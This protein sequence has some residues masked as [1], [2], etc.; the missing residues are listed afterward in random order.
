M[1]LNEFEPL[2]LALRQHPLAF[3]RGFLAGLVGLTVQ[4]P[5]AAASTSRPQ[6]IAID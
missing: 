2:L 3:G 5:R 6:T 1:L 4:R